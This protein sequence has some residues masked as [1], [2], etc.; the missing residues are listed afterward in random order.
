MYFSERE[1]DEGLVERVRREE[2]EKLRVR[3]F[4]FQI[5]QP[6]PLPDKDEVK[7]GCRGEGQAGG[8]VHQP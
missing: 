5:H 1:E 6:S 7:E 2:R 8:D 3:F 4:L